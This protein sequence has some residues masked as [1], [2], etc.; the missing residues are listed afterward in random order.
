MKK[1]LGAE[2][3]QSFYLM[4]LMALMVTL[5]VGLGLLAVRV[6]G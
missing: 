4:G 2:I 5:Y 6:L 3:G 1:S